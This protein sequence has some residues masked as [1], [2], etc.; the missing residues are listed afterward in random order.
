MVAAALRQ[1][2]ASARGPATLQWTKSSSVATRPSS[3]PDC[4]EIRFKSGFSTSSDTT[5]P[6]MGLLG[7]VAAGRHRKLEGLSDRGE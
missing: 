1:A 5:L 4:R 2:A 7:R 6:V 3:P